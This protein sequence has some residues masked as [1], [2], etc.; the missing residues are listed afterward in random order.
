M[1][2]HAHRSLAFRA[3]RTDAGAGRVARVRTAQTRSARQ[4]GFTLIELVV[5][6]SII[7]ILAAVALPRFMNLQR[8][9]RVGHLQGVRGAFVSGATVVHATLLARRG[10]PDAAPCP[11]GAGA[12]ADNRAADSGTA[13]TEGGIV[14][15][16]HGYPASSNDGIVSA[17]G[18]GTSFNPSAADLAAD[19]YRVVVAGT[20]A[21]IQ[22]VDAPAPES[23]GFTYTEPAVSGSAPLFSQPLTAGC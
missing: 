21:T 16:M 15:T 1:N 11:A 7:A 14:R 13:C 20:T 8:D 6:L 3:F 19:G 22:R 5:V 2:S 17:A 23:C 12:T 18:L 9:A 10:M 4:A